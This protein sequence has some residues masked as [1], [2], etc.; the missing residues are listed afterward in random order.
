MISSKN[1]ISILTHRVISDQNIS[2]NCTLMR[3]VEVARL[4]MFTKLNVTMLCFEKKSAAGVVN[5]LV[6]RL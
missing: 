2:L 4:D 3:V 1:V 6:V 5:R